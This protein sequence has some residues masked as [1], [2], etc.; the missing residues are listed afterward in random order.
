MCLL[1][2]EAPRK[3][4]GTH[5]TVSAECNLEGGVG[6]GGWRL[7]APAARTMASITPSPL[8]LRTQINVAHTTSDSGLVEVT[9]SGVAVKKDGKH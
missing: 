5:F 9:H 2:A 8:G 7:S 3:K 1:G 4:F 6:D